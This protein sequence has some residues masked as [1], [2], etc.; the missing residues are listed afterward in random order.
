MWLRS[1]NKADLKAVNALLVKT[2]HATFDDVL[3]VETVMQVTDE[4]HSV[5]ALTRNLDKPYSEFVVADDGEGNLVGMAFASQSKAGI[6]ELH[7]LYVDP[8]HQVQGIGTQLLAEIEM[9][10]PDVEKLSLG[11]VSKNQKALDFYL[12]KGF[13][14]TG[15][16]KDWGRLN[17]DVVVV[18]MEKSLS[19]W[20]I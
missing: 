8:E 10:F 13:M 20:S 1:A 9:A 15:E 7:Q 6:A 5:A 18:T 11:V 17:L 19:G 4:F 14:K 16:T 12:R 3:G 2:M